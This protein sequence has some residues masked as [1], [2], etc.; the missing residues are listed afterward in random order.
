L[1]RILCDQLLYK[2]LLPRV[3]ASVV[4]GAQ[5]EGSLSPMM[6]MVFIA[7]TLYIFSWAPLINALAAAVLCQSEPTEEGR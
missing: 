2:L 6:A 3:V 7:Q 1:S 5:A 4:P